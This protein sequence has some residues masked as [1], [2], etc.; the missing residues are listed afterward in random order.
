MGGG[1]GG[2]EVV[3]IWQPVQLK[4]E[5]TIAARVWVVE[6]L[7][8]SHCNDS[9]DPVGSHYFTTLASHGNLLVARMMIAT[10]FM[11]TA[12]DMYNNCLRTAVWKFPSLV[13]ESY[14]VCGLDY[15]EK[16]ASS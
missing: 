4:R 5:I 7:S 10:G 13:T 12:T 3:V 2:G 1:L 11:S 14:V 9:H 6:H 16:E 8:T 15:T